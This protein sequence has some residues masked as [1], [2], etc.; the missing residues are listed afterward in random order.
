[1]RELTACAASAGRRRVCAAGEVLALAG[2]AVDVVLVVEAGALE[3]HSPAGT[4][5]VL[6]PGDGAGA[7]AVLAPGPWRVT[8]VAR[9]DAVVVEF[10]CVALRALLARA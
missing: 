9:A 10:D 3:L 6:G 4:T 2:N 1:M 5:H 8:V 7:W